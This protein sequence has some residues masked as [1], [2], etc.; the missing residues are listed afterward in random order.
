MLS[1]G[2]ARDELNGPQVLPGSYDARYE[3]RN[4]AILKANSDGLVAELLRFIL[5]RRG[6]WSEGSL[7]T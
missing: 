3:M 5:G 2:E 1:K 4:Y 7:N 6:V